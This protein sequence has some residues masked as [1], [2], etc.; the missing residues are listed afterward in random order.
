MIGYEDLFPTYEEWSVDAH[1]AMPGHHLQVQGHLEHFLDNCG[2]AIAW[3]DG[4]T[5]YTGFKEGWAIYAE[6]PLIGRDTDTYAD[7]PMQKYGM[8]KWLV[9]RS[10][11]LIVDPGLNHFGMKRDEVIDYFKHYAWD[12]SSSP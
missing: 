4:L 5:S 7:E 2:G 1:E 11:R 12:N 6:Y 3:L 10:I 9:W 8:L